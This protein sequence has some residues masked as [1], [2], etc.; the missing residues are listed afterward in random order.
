MA[1]TLAFAEPCLPGLL[2]SYETILHG[3]LS[4]IIYDPTFKLPRSI[5]LLNAYDQ[6]VGNVMAI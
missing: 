6:C 4:M 3:S 1:A 2:W 5:G